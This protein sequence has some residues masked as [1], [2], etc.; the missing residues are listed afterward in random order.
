MCLSDPSA[1]CDL[2]AGF[3]W[4][5]AVL[6]AFFLLLLLSVAGFCFMQLHVFPNPLETHLPRALVSDDLPPAS[7]LRVAIAKPG[8]PSFAGAHHQAHFGTQVPP[9]YMSEQLS[10][11]TKVL[12][13]G[14]SQT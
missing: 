14:I 2:L 3:Q 7:T 9:C 1:C 12:V 10:P 5:L 11:K 4:V 6:S 8:F 13:G